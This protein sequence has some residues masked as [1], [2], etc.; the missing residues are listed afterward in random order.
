MLKKS[1]ESG[2]VGRLA[3]QASLAWNAFLQLRHG[4]GPL[5]FVASPPV[6]VLLCFA[7]QEEMKFFAPHRSCGKGCQLATTF[8]VWMTGIG[9]KNAAE[10]VRKAIARMRPERVIT[11]GFAGGFDAGFRRGFCGL[12]GGHA[13]LTP[14]R[15]GSLPSSERR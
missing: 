1:N 10:N 15:A 2:P 11:A 5:G 8:Q 6:D 14:R 4:H 3:K 12:C 7:V 13:G 9:R